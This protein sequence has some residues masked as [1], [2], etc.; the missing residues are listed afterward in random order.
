M[1][2]DHSAPPPLSVTRSRL[3]VGL[4]LGAG[5]LT[6]LAYHAGVLTALENDLGWDV[7]TADVI[8]GTSAGSIVAT[9]LRAGVPPSDLA[10]RA[11]GLEPIASPP[12]ATAAFADTPELPGFSLRSLLRPPR[13]P[14]PGLLAAL[15]SRPWRV[16]PVTTAM[17]LL[18]DG[19]LDV[20][21]S[22]TGIVAAIG[23]Q[24]PSDPTW[25][26]AVRQ[27]DLRRVV[28]GRDLDASP[29]AAV[30]A[31]CAVPGYFSPVEVHD[32]RYLDGGVHSP[33]NA[34]VLARESLDLVVVVSPMSARRPGN[35]GVDALARRYAGAK[36]RREIDVLERN[37][38][39]TV[40]LEPGPDLVRL[41]GFDVMAATHTAEITGAAI[42]D[43]GEQIRRPGV[44]TVLAGLGSPR[45]RADL[46]SSAT[47]TGAS[48][49]S[50]VGGGRPASVG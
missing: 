22:Q 50:S 45:R 21:A 34:A 4:V 33:T 42:L 26:C 47:S 11:V 49:S 18:A 31:S 3:R 28:F 32:E 15:A 25:I 17:G 10:A 12:D 9:M 36:L 20:L 41:M 37:D 40:V 13:F 29:A 5:G 14:D 7:R 1:R 38:V 30:A 24:W 39:P 6:G 2:P 19:P 43:A 35:V 16:D 27:R 48:G 23:A 46:R 8:V 44:R